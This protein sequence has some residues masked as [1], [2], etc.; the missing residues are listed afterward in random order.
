MGAFYSTKYAKD[1]EKYREFRLGT[2]AA[3]LAYARSVFGDTAGVSPRQHILAIFAGRSQIPSTSSS[4][5]TNVGP[6]RE[7]ER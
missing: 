5:S 3:V 7:V 6:C 4:D 1:R 2:A